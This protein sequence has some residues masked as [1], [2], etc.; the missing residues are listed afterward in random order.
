MLVFN[1]KTREPETKARIISSRYNVSIEPVY[2]DLE[3]FKK[4]FH[5]QKKKF[6]HDLKKKKLIVTGIEWWV[7]LKNEEA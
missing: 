7:E 6:F 5:N 4:E 3:V 1:K 2:L